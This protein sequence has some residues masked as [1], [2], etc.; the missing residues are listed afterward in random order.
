M[1]LPRISEAVEDYVAHS[2]MKEKGYMVDM[3]SH[4]AFVL[5]AYKGGLLHDSDLQQLSIYPNGYGLNIVTRRAAARA[6]AR[7]DIIPDQAVPDADRRSR[8]LASPRVDIPF[9]A[10]LTLSCIEEGLLHESTITPVMEL[11]P[12][13]GYELVTASE[14]A[15]G[16]LLLKE[17]R[18]E[19][20]LYQDGVHTEEV[21]GTC[22]EGQQFH[23]ESYSMDFFRLNLPQDIDDDF[24][25]VNILLFKTL[26]ALSHYCVP[27]HTPASWMGKDGVYTYHV[28]EA[29]EALKERIKT[30]TRD[31]LVDFLTDL[32]CDGVQFETFALGFD[33]DGPH[34]EDAVE[35][36]CD[37]LLDMHELEN[38]F[39]YRL[40]YGPETTEAT[41]KAEMEAMQLQAK[42]M[43]GN[44]SSHERVLVAIMGA[45]ETCIDLVEHHFPIHG[46]Q[47]PGSEEEGIG[48]FETILV[49]VEDRMMGL[50]EESE[51]GFNSCAENCGHIH[52]GLP[53]ESRELVAQTTIPIIK[54]TQQCLAHLRQI[55][56]SLEVPPNA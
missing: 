29:Y 22:I 53:L 37:L 42:E 23:L 36:A 20:V 30:S 9:A 2:F 28:G 40:A 31:E 44:G 7:L 10:N 50:F 33:G 51:N 48:F 32:N 52:I 43:I 54:R 55:Q 5:D 18:E 34:D 15:L 46:Q 13:C 45:L 11:G 6:A 21:I 49:V 35:H 26:D 24:F 41:R 19:R 17:Q 14:K 3:V 38:N 39:A 25:G 47:F 56:I 1:T 27:F 12:E 4:S 8:I 16:A